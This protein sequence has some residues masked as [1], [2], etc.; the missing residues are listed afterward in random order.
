MVGATAPQNPTGT[1][2]MATGSSPDATSPAPA[3]SS[4]ANM[5]GLSD[6]LW[7]ALSWAGAGAG[8]YHGY[9]RNNSVGW[10]IGWG[11]LG[12]WFPLFTVP[13]AFAQGFGKRA[14]K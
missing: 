4:M 6:A 2:S 10:A 1:S 14:K 12:A 9:K 3:T 5:L 11:I 13:I 8:A 7:T